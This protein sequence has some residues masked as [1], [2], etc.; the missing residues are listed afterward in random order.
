MSPAPLRRISTRVEALAQLSGKVC[1]PVDLEMFRGK[2]M[3]IMRHAYIVSC[4]RAVERF[5]GVKLSALVDLYGMQC[6][7]FFHWFFFVQQGEVETK[8]THRGTL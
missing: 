5:V 3:D 7:K 6:R 8:Q 1:G 4:G 2:N